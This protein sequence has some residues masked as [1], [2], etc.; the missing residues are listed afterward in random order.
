MSD[1]STF[2]DQ[3][4]IELIAH[5][6]LIRISMIAIAAFYAILNDTSTLEISQSRS[7]AKVLKKGK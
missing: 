3:Q 1:P 7:I 4:E 5:D 2:S 6:S